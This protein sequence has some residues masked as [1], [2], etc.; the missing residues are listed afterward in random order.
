MASWASRDRK[1]PITQLGISGKAVSSIGLFLLA[2][3]P[4]QIYTLT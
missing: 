1:S 3:Q 2:F 4:R